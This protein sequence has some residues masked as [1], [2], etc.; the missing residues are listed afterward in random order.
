MSSSK[1]ASWKR[2]PIGELAQRRKA[3]KEQYIAAERET[4]MLQ[5]KVNIVKKQANE[6][7]GRYTFCNILYIYIYIY[8]TTDGTVSALWASSV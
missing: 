5:D 1:A 8:I 2:F 6:L 3:L 4:S 7:K